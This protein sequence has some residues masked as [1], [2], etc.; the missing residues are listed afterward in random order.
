MAASIKT[1]GTKIHQFAFRQTRG[2][3]RL[4]DSDKFNRWGGMRETFPTLAEADAFAFRCW[5]FKCGR[6]GNPF[7]RTP[8]L[9]AREA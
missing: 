7:L 1:H 9:A 3:F 6:G 2:G 4:I 5:A 8:A